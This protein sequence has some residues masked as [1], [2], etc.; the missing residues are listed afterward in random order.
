[1]FVVCLG[2]VTAGASTAWTSPVL[3]QIVY[4]NGTNLSSGLTLTSTQIAIVGSS[5][6]LA[7]LL[8]SIPA[9]YITDK[10]GR[11]KSILLWQL[12]FILSSLLLGFAKNAVM[13]YI[14]RFAGGLGV[15]AML[16]LC[17]T[18][19]SEVADTGVRG[20]L[21][22]LPSSLGWVGIIFT[23]TMGAVLHWRILTALLMVLPAL[24]VILVWRLPET[25]AYLFTN[26]KLEAAK[27]ALIYFNGPSYDIV[28]ELTVLEKLD[29]ER[30][31]KKATIENLF[32]VTQHRRALVI[33][34]LLMVLQQS[35]GVNVIIFYSG[36]IFKAAGNSINSYTASIIIATVKVIFAHFA[37]LVME[38]AGRRVFM[39]SSLMGMCACLLVMGVFFNLKE[40]SVALPTAFDFLPIISLCLFCIFF[41]LG[42][43]PIPL[44]I[45]GE[46]FPPSV[47]G[48]ASGL[49]CIVHFLL[50]FV[51]T[52]IFPIVNDLFG[53][54]FAFYLF[55]FNTAAGS[56]LVYFLQ[57]E[58]RNKSFHEV[59]ELLKEKFR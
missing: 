26:G 48:L 52:F 4:V 50:I 7:A 54:F 42:A 40:Y 31:A 35:C 2:I 57:P 11:R 53:K 25:P 49:T 39:L 46:L 1:M 15:G 12:A 22:S 34:V 55:A 38:R 47:K 14:G 8:V 51:F 10:I 6:P 29:S 9:G 24:T 41:C 18:Y 5:L 44:F 32:S 58:T 19:I 28:K 17:T 16:I 37:A 30:I 33:A 59:Q 27:Q 3:P 36:L 13:L 20:Q 43:G 23:Y 21:G 45:V 56:V